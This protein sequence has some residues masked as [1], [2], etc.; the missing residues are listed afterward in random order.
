VDARYQEL[1]RKE[2]EHWGRGTL[3]PENPKIWNDPVLQEIFFGAEQRRLLERA[4]ACGPRVLELGCGDGD[5]AVDLAQRGL[6]VTAIDVS[7]DRIRAAR[8]LAAAQ[9]ATVTF[10][11]GDLN[12]MDLP[13]GP[14]DCVLVHDALHHVYALD[15]LLANVERVLAPGGRL[16]V[17]DFCGMGRGARA[18]AAAILAVF[19]TYMPYARKW[20]MRR[21]LGPFLATERD[22][23]TALERGE[24]SG[25]H[26]GSPFESISQESIVP[27]IARRFEVVEH[28]RFLPFWWYVAPKLRLGRL[29]HRAARWFRRWD[30][31]LERRRLVRG[32]YFTVEARHRNNAPSPPEKSSSGMPGRDRPDQQV[33]GEGRA[34]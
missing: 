32:A 27:A 12:T 29:Q 17:L 33:A 23:R 6:E 16:L 25:L 4:A 9:G 19:P 14:F 5:H 1:V 15:R 31:G 30:D 3:D 21:R 28:R 18:L 22:K 2:A 20:G 8:E 11:V 34:D 10:L 13:A 7:L 24:H 26:E